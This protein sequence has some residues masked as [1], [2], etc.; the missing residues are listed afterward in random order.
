[1]QQD[2]LSCAEAESGPRKRK[3]GRNIL[4][5]NGHRAQEGRRRGGLLVFLAIPQ[6]TFLG[7]G[8]RFTQPSVL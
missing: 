6:L 8:A 4:T 1:M 2:F 3:V 7:P 5:P